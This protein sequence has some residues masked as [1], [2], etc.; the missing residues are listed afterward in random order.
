MLLYTSTWNLHRFDKFKF[1]LVASTTD[2]PPLRPPALNRFMAVR[3]SSTLRRDLCIGD[4]SALL[5]SPFEQWKPVRQ[6]WHHVFVLVAIATLAEARTVWRHGQAVS[7]LVCAVSEQQLNI[8]TVS[9]A[10][11]VSLETA[12]AFAVWPVWKKKQF[13]VQFAIFHIFSC[14]ETCTGVS[15]ALETMDNAQKSFVTF[16]GIECTPWFWRWV[17]GPARGY[18]CRRPNNSSCSCSSGFQPL[19]TRRTL[20]QLSKLLPNPV[21]AQYNRK[22]KWVTEM[23]SINSLYLVIQRSHGFSHAS[24][25]LRRTQQGVRSKA[26]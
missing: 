8:F 3:T 20:M 6:K 2:R 19:R 1:A 9:V 24:D 23:K 17:Q 4:D 12:S 13:L 22:Y 21:F 7:L 10:T 18:Q 14:R 25:D 5:Q 26:G 11:F 15:L 16:Q